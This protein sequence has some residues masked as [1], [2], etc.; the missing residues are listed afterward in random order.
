MEST[1][2]NS[3]AIYLKEI[4][5][6][7][8]DTAK[9][10]LARWKV[11]LLVSL[12]VALT[13][14][15]I[16]YRSTTQYEAEC[17]FV[18]EEGGGQQ[19]LGQ[20]GGV[21]AIIGMNIEGSSGLFQGDN[22]IQLYKSRRM[23]GKTL[24]MP[25]GNGQR[26]LNEYI[27]FSG[28]KDE[29][30]DDGLITE[31]ELQFKEK[32][33]TLNQDRLIGR[34]VKRINEQNLTIGRPDKKLGVISV[35][36]V[37]EDESFS[38][39]FTDLLVQNVNEFYIETKIK[40]SQENV[41]VLQRQT[42]SVRTVMAVSMGRS[43]ATLDQYANINLSRQRLRLPSQR[44]QVDATVAG[45][46]Y[47]QLIQN[48]ELAKISLRR[49]TPLIQIIDSPILPLKRNS[50]SVVFMFVVLGISAGIITSMALLARK[51]VNYIMRQ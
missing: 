37:S 47:E 11:I 21:A 29:F 23:I 12:A 18:L 51:F 3:G 22:I 44:S 39:R 9:Y 33:H 25:A 35:K 30:V 1:E 5:V 49:E 7:T 32:T 17:T 19:G 24:L 6:E 50:T 10:L 36:F 13:G 46:A 45:K 42:D 38:K 26:L 28:M 16:A 20:L 40:R 4:F 41:D 15:A 27:A 8:R 14:A 48:L 31:K 34:V 2:K 43:V